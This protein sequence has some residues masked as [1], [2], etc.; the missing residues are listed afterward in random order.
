M[1]RN[2]EEVLHA[3]AAAEAEARLHTAD[4]VEARGILL[5]ATEYMAEAVEAATAQGVISGDL[6]ATVSLIHSRSHSMLTILSQAAEAYMSLGNVSYPRTNTRYFRE[7]LL[8]L[9]RAAELPGYR[10]PAWLQQ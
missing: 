6:L 1:N 8:Y 4:Y 2:E 9:R 10:L 7:A 5:P 3:R